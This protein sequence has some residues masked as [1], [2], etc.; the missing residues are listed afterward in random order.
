MRI[1]HVTSYQ[2]PGYGYE[3]LPLARA[4]A[5]LGH[6]VSIVT[7]N[8]LHPLGQYAVLSGRFP[9]RQVEP[10]IDTVGNVQIFRLRGVE[11][12]R[13]VWIRG[14]AKQI[15]T[16][17]PDV[18]HCHNLIQFHPIRLSA[19]KA[20]RKSEMGLVIDDHMHTS[21]ARRSLLGH[22]FYLFYRHTVHRLVVK[23]TDALFAISEDTRRY[24][25]DFCGVKGPVGIMPLGVDTD[26]F[27]SSPERRSEARKRFGFTDD[28]LVFLYTGKVIE[29]KGVR[30]L[31]TATIAVLRSG[32]NARVLIVGDADQAYLR[33]LLDEAAAAGYLDR[34]KAVPSVLHDQIPEIYAAA[35]VAV[36]PR[37]ESMAIFEAM[38]MGIPVVVSDACGYADILR[39]GA[40][41]LFESEKPESLALAMRS[42]SSPSRRAE[43][44]RYGALLVRRDRSWARSAERYL[45][46]YEQV[47]QKVRIT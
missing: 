5:T 22:L 32:D 46:A 12:A 44:G 11:I 34:I 41:V 33:S 35:D 10:R 17:R 16:L 4:Q 27:T 43:L 28:D 21:V 3:E 19:L 15:E 13:R 26:A 2:V 9:T 36:W 14:L 42:L 25:T 7:S 30:L 29:A 20:R 18:V 23:N 1:V 40:G 8:Y 6:Q 45:W 24:L 38:S 37:Q 31:I 39:A 47:I